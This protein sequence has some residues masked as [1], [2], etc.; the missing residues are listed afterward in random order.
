M[1][2]FGR[3]AATREGMTVYLSEFGVGNHCACLP[4]KEMVAAGQP[5]SQTGQSGYA[6]RGLPPRPRACTSQPIDRACSCIASTT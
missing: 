5:R 4:L 1:F 6:Y 3:V 2:R